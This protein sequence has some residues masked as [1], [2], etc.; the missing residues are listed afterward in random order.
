MCLFCRQYVKVRLVSRPWK[1]PEGTVNRP[2]LRMM[3]ESVMAYIMNHPG[4]TI[5]VLSTK[6]NP[7][8]D[9]VP[10]YELVQVCKNLEKKCYL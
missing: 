7:V 4:A 1:T 6:Y 3:L 9:T 8:L 5:D 10:I 2:S